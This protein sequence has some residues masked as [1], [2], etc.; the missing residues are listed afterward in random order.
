LIDA[1]MVDLAGLQAPPEL[2]ADIADRLRAAVGDAF[3]AGFRAVSLIAAAVAMAGAIT[4]A[5]T[6]PTQENVK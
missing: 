5:L 3:V 1:R 6:I 4:A 2:G